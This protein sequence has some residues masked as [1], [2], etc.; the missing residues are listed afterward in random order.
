[1]SAG[2]EPVSGP[3]E[4]EPLLLLHVCC[5]PCGG[6]CVERLLA[7]GRQVRLYYS[8]SN[9]ADAEE[10]EHRLEW[11]RYLADLFR[12]ELE[13]DPYDH[14]AW[15]RHVSGLEAEPERGL[16][17]TACFGFSLGRTALRAQE[18][19]CHFATTLTVSPKKSSKIIFDVGGR[20]EG[21]EPWDFKKHDGY[22]R[23]CRIAAE[24]GFY[25][26]GFCGCEFSRR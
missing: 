2:R 13:V 22:L 3:P 24:H 6:G 17:C 4:K 7:E 8:N 25:R 11:V 10:F 16:R 5:A 12:V 14:A 15:L 20:Y 18:L 19:G 21:F 9:L 26:Q 23:S 1:V